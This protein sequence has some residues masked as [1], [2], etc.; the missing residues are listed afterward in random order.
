MAIALIVNL[1]A[2]R[3]KYN[4]HIWSSSVKRVISHFGILTRI[5][6]TLNSFLLLIDPW[7]NWMVTILLA[8][9]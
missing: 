3:L 6:L 7:R 5:V 1:Y 4:K 2:A 8:F 9:S